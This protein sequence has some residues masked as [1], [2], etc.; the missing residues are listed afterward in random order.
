MWSI[1]YTGRQLIEDRGSRPVASS[2]PFDS[3]PSTL[4]RGLK[5]VALLS[6]GTD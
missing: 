5:S 2:P 1:V 6:H 3:W 4:L